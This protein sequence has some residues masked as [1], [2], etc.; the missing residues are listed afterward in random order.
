M[1]NHKRFTF[2]L[3]SEQ[4]HEPPI[5]QRYCPLRV[6]S[7]EERVDSRVSRP[8]CWRYRHG[9]HPVSEGGVSAPPQRL[10]RSHPRAYDLHCPGEVS[11]LQQRNRT[12]Q[13][14]GTIPCLRATI[15]AAPYT[16]DKLRRRL[17]QN[18]RL[19]FIDK[20]LNG[21]RMVDFPWLNWAR[22]S[23][24]ATGSQSL[25]SAVRVGASA[26]CRRG[27]ERSATIRPSGSRR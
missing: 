18:Y 9:A 20:R 5:V 10:L 24:W 7:T 11:F 22:R 1:I 27:S 6:V 26:Q 12:L 4:H 16:V 14:T 8:R 3:D 2:I 17:L 13:I 15:S 19:T 21:A 23:S 25:P